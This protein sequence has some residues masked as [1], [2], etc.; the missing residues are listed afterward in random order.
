MNNNE[1]DFVKV[2][3]T[4][5]V[6]DKVIAIDVEKFEALI[7]CRVEKDRLWSELWEK[8]EECKR[9]KAQNDELIA[10]LLTPAPTYGGAV[11]DTDT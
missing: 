10:K 1:F 8:R 4:E 9:L 3:R 2:E 11:N 5:K 6:S 7:E